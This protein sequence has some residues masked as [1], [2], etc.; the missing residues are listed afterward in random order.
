MH[1][2][3]C[4]NFT[5]FIFLFIVVSL[6]LSTHWVWLMKLLQYHQDLVTTLH[7][8]VSVLDKQCI[9]DLWCLR[10]KLLISLPVGC[11]A[12]HGCSL[13]SL[14]KNHHNSYSTSIHDIFFGLFP[15]SSHTKSEWVC[16]LRLHCVYMY[17][18][19]NNKYSWPVLDWENF[20]KGV[21]VCIDWESKWC[22][23]VF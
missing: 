21:K 1:S 15:S 8:S 6:D 4:S 19:S 22:T 20:S 16:W 5:L 17:E 11:Y 14:F 23:C 12:C 7:R 10:V 3:V 9:L 18:P 2:K 13:V